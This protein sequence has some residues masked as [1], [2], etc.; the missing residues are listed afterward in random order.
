VRAE[1]AGGLA[2]LRALCAGPARPPRHL[3]AFDG[4]PGNFV[5][6]RGRAILVDLEKC[7]YSY[8][9]L[10]LAHATL[11]TSTTWDIDTHA[12]LDLPEVVAAYTDW[13]SA[14]GPQVAAAARGWHLPLRRAMWLWSLTWCAK[15]RVESAR[16]RATRPDGED[17]STTRSDAALVAHVRARVDHYLDASLVARLVAGSDTLERALAP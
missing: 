8:P 16:Q 7:R 6:R 13:A 1:V 5:L 10:D 3:I 4:H 9:G 2:A 12:V 15:W 11:Y 17:W 14:Q